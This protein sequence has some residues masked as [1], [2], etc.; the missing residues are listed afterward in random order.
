MTDIA[1]LGALAIVAV[2]FIHACR[3]EW[4]GVVIVFGL[5]LLLGSCQII[6]IK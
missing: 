3:K 5:V 2:V 4:E 6:G 1:K